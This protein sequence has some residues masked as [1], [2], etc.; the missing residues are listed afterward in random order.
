MVKENYRKV[1]QGASGGGGGSSSSKPAATASSSTRRNAHVEAR[2]ASSNATDAAN[3][4]SGR[5]AVRAAAGAAAGAAGIVVGAAAGVAVGAAA[6]VA[7]GAAF[8]AGHRKGSEGEIRA[9]SSSPSRLR[10]RGGSDGPGGLV[11]DAELRR[12]AEG[13]RGG[14]GWIPI[15]SPGEEKID[16]SGRARPSS[17]TVAS[18]R[19]GN[20]SSTTGSASGLGRGARGGESS[21]ASGSRKAKAGA[22]PT[23]LG[24]G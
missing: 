12:N 2:G 4:K 9:T 16:A 24:R 8:L 18:S 14:G 17:A 6:G 10:R 1:T 13:R 5:Q 11:A 22:G 3:A 7:V 19:R 21:G 20:I 15:S 23:W